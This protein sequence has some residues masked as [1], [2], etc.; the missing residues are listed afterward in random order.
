M[1]DLLTKLNTVSELEIGIG[2]RKI[3]FGTA[4]IA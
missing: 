2:L 4:V 3:D 1:Y